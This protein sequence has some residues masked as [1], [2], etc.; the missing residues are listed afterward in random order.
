MFTPGGSHAEL[1]IPMIVS[2]LKQKYPQV[3]IE[4]A[5]PYNMDD[6]AG[7]LALRLY[8]MKA[9]EVVSA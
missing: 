9:K 2:D 5:W 6:V 8:Q 1:E 7:L 4:Y 3:S